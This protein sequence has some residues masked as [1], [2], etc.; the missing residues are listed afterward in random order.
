MRKHRC[1]VGSNPT[2][3]SLAHYREHVLQHL[4]AA[5]ETT[6]MDRRRSLS[7]I[8]RPYQH[9]RGVGYSFPIFR[10][11]RLQYF[12]ESFLRS[13]ILPM[14]FIRSNQYRRSSILHMENHITHHRDSRLNTSLYISHIFIIDHILFAHQARYPPNTYVSLSTSAKPSVTRDSL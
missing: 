7:R 12:F 6:V 14:S 10:E 5:F 2:P 9:F 8:L 13:V 1:A 11:Q 4:Q 3:I